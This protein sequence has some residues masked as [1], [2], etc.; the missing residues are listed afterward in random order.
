MHDCTSIYVS[1]L[2]NG[3]VY[4]VCMS[5]YVYISKIVVWYHTTIYVYMYV[6]VI[7]GM[8]SI[9]GDLLRLLLLLL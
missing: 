6:C 5:I 4:H 8:G 9:T 7:S 3:M 1:K 2:F